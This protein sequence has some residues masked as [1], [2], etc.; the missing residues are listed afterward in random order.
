MTK[1]GS[2][3]RLKATGEQA[4][5]VTMSKECLIR[6]C[7]MKSVLFLNLLIYLLH[8]TVRN[9]TANICLAFFMR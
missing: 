7:I 3:A 1:V 8:L 4:G 2:L 5:R 9:T 6:Y